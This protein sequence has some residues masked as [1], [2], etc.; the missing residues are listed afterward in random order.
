MKKMIL[1]LSLL[2]T[3]TAFGA[4]NILL[5]GDS[6]TA[7]SFGIT[8]HA[9]LQMIDGSKVA[10]FGNCGSSPHG[11]LSHASWATT[12][13]GYFHGFVDGSGI[14]GKTKKTPYLPELLKNMDIK[15]PGAAIKPNFI[16]VALGANQLPRVSTVA[17]YNKE[18][19]RVIALVDRIKEVNIPCL[20]VGPTDGSP[21]RKPKV[22]QD[23][24]YKMLRQ[25]HQES[26][27]YCQFMSS[28]ESAL[29]I[30]KYPTDCYK[31]GVH[32]DYCTEG[33]IK[34]VHWSNAVT[35]KVQEM[36]Q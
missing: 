32:W 29:P 11:W 16:I 7:Q 31:D 35:K 5:I 3:T 17:G 10:S 30:M 15:N 1:L 24:L 20:W 9:N 4:T 23:K 34:A 8:L 25:A 6:H 28:R 21:E 27:N 13:C 12:T 22:K 19:A 2:I 14:R 36:L 33:R 26:G 18:K